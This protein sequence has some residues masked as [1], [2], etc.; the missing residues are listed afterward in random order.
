MICWVLHHLQ[1]LMS[2]KNF[3]MYIGN[4]DLLIADN[5]KDLYFDYQ[6]FQYF[7]L[8]LIHLTILHFLKKVPVLNAMQ[9]IRHKMY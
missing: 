1:Y 8:L 5:Y 4:S 6:Q 2:L 3:R 7:L 9:Q